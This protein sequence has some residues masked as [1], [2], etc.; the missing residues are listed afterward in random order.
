MG[1]ISRGSRLETRLEARGILVPLLRRAFHGF[2]N[3]LDLFQV[4]QKLAPAAAKVFPPRPF[5]TGV[6][7]LSATVKVAAGHFEAAFRV[8]HNEFLACHILDS[9][10]RGTAAQPVSP[11][12]FGMGG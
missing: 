7:A 12:R 1:R 10:R 5:H 9:A 11:D 8:E 2:V 3:P 4:L 6:F